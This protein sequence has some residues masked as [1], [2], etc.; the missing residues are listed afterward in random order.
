MWR[1]KKRLRWGKKVVVQ[2]E[3]LVTPQRRLVALEGRVMTIY[4][5]FSM[6]RSSGRKYG[7]WRSKKRL[8]HNSTIIPVQHA[9]AAV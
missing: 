3:R 8:Q 9:A 5:F 7:L 1:G 2:K 4:L 6:N